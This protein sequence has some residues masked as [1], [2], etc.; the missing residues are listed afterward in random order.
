MGDFP[1]FQVDFQKCS[2]NYYLWWWDLYNNF[3][4][5]V[6]TIYLEIAGLKPVMQSRITFNIKFADGKELMKQ[7]VIHTINRVPAE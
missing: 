7:E 4:S 5:Q 6:K 1:D 3:F 2:K